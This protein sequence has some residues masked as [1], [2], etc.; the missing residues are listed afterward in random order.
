MLN[1]FNLINCKKPFVQ[2]VEYCNIW[3]KRVIYLV[4]VM[5][6]ILKNTLIK[7]VVGIVTAKFNK[8]SYLYV[9]YLVTTKIIDCQW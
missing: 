7:L 3:Y 6:V 1:T 5:A 9:N 8:R 2:G 4:V